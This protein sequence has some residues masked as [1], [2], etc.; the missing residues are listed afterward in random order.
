MHNNGKTTSLLLLRQFGFT[1]SVSKMVV[2]MWKNPNLRISAPEKNMY[3]IDY[4]IRFVAFKKKIPMFA[5]T[6]LL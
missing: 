5:A 3:F 2:L 4:F 6:N 1:R